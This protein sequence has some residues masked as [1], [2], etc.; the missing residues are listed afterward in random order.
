MN[1]IGVAYYRDGTQGL[2]DA[3][4]LCKDTYR[5]ACMMHQYSRLKV[6]RENCGMRLLAQILINRDI[7]RLDVRYMDGTVKDV[8]FWT[9]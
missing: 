3:E 5:A 6:V 7:V 4:K 9:K 2:I 1:T 8:L